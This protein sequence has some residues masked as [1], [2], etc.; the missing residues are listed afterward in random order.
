MSA[1]NKHDQF[2]YTSGATDSVWVHKDAYSN[3][4]QFQKL[5]TNIETDVCVIGA[6]ISG[7]STAYELVLQ[8]KNVVLI[9]ARDVISGETGRTSGHLSNAL[10]DGY[11]NI[12]SKHKESGAKSAAES[13]TWALNHV[14]EVAGKLEID[15]EYRK[16]PGY[17][18]SQYSR[19][20]KSHAKDVEGI[21]AEV[22]LAAQIGVDVEYK[23][24]LAVKGWDGTTDQRDGAIFSNQAAFHPTLYLVGVLK[25]LKQQRN[26]QCY[27][28][29]RIV[30]LEESGTNVLLK[31]EQ[32]QE[33]HCQYAVEATAVPLQKLSII[34][35]MACHR[36]YCIAARIP[37]GSVEDCFIYDTAD[38]YK[39][40]RL[41]E[42]DDK[43]DYMIVG[44][45]D[46]KVGQ[47]DTSGHFEELEAWARERFTSI[48]SV[49][50]KW[51]G[52]VWEPVDYVG[53][54]GKN[55]GCE[56]IY[57]VTGDSGNGLTHAVLGSRLIADQICGKQNP[58]AGLYSPS[59]IASIVKSAKDLVLHDVQVNAQ[60]GR[61]L[62]T[63]LQDIEDL[64]VGSGGV[65]NKGLSKPVAVYKGEN[66]QVVKMSALCPHLKGVVCWNATEKSFDCPIHGSRF[67]ETGL[68]INGPAKMGLEVLE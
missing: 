44:G 24:G 2:F 31:T 47:G 15:C 3:R 37:K 45:G 54:I 22:E 11:V 26:F 18:I 41:T 8:G 1:L 60:Y 64:A 40:V 9:D 12:K 6:G 68:C 42:C 5:Q 52:Q 28:F 14:G 61:F 17:K 4:P 13:H 19:D 39:Y 7:I 66:G 10:D 30:S 35:E 59:R 36:T 49:D 29:T 53:F 27:T 51:S 38:P 55:Q 58:W 25:W 21:K 23:E 67:S 34:V 63:D 32:G 43:D 56:R 65:L 50:Y 48:K 62:Q 57:V 46:H 33:I 20:D 16:V